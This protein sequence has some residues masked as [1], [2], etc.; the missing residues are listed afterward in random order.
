[1]SEA[2]QP[3]PKKLRTWSAFGDIRKMPTEYE[4]VTHETNYS[5]RS[6]RTSSFESNPTTPANIWYLTY[7]ENSPLKCEIWTGFRDPSE[8]TYRK[9]VTHQDSQEAVL[10]GV[11]HEHTEAKHDVALDVSWVEALGRWLVPQRY[12]GHALQMTQEIGRAHV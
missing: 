12:V 9:Y 11:A 10:E 8:T 6:G 4:I 5:M 3:K 7:R 1:M 2:S